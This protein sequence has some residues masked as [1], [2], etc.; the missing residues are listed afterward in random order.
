[1]RVTA[2]RWHVHV[3]GS[4]AHTCPCRG[5]SYFGYSRLCTLRLLLGT[6]LLRFRAHFLVR[7]I[8]CATSNAA[9]D[10]ARESAVTGRMTCDT[11][12]E[13]AFD[14]AF[15]DGDAWGERNRED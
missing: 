8:R 7:S 4:A 3:L 14:A 1:V 6:L 15:G 2:M 10:S 13:C 9:H 5:G 12:N 11:A